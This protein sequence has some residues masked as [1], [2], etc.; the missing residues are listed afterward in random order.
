[1][2]VTKGHGNPNWTRDEVVLALDLYLDFAPRIPGPTESRVIELSAIL[3]SIP[4]HAF[5]ARK[6]SFRNPDGVAFKL[7]NLNQVAT[8]R[9]LSNVSRVDR[10][11]WDEFGSDRDRVR[12]AADLIRT[13]LKLDS[14]SVEDLEDPDVFA[15]GE[16][17]TRLHLHRERSRTLRSR[18]IAFRLK[19]GTL[20]CDM[21][22]RESSDFPDDL[23]S[24]A[25]E[26]HH[27]IPLSH[28]GARSTMVKDLSLL[29]AICHRLLH[30]LIGSRKRWLSIEEAKA[31]LK[32]ARKS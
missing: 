19:K 20:R 32:V 25:F 8:G 13:A 31:E 26:V 10:L 3:R 9:G 17:L 12:I 15:E 18:F 14:G 16:I 5:A 1:M 22:A 29:C 11:V 27:V 30:R 4:F 28:S 6:D 23:W 24:A 21:C 7:Q 2:A